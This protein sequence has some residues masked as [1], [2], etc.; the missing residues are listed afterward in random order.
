MIGVDDGFNVIITRVLFRIDKRR[1]AHIIDYLTH[2]FMAVE[3][4]SI[5]LMQN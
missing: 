4:K 1:C 2:S 5:Q 3:P